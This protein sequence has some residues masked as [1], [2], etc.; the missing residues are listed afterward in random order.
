MA[1]IYEYIRTQ[2]YEPL[3]FEEHCA[4]LEETAR[5]LYSLSWSINRKELRERIATELQGGGYSSLV[6]NAVKVCIHA[7]SSIE[8]VPEEVLYNQFSARAIRPRI[9]G[10]ELVA[11]GSSLTENSSAKEALI[12]LHRAKNQHLDNPN[13]PT[14]WVTEQEEVVAID[15]S[16]VIAV[17]EDEVIFSECG[18]GIEFDLAYNAALQ[19]NLNPRRGA[20]LLSQLGR[21]KELLSIDHRGIT[22]I[23]RWEEHHYMDLTASMI[24]A[25]IAKNE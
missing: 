6:A 14:I 16:A 19:K 4:R 24:A 11:K 12:E 1:Y 23:E 18:F 21:A 15:G 20:I 9:C 5:R 3:H 10:V 13:E 25:E 2:G 17:F 8:I 22:A 7:D